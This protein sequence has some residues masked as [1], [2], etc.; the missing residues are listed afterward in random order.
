[1]PE[2]MTKYHGLMRYADDMVWNFPEG[3][4]GFEER[5]RFLPVELAG[6]RPV[7]F[8][9]SLEDPQLCFVTLPVPV[10]EYCSKG[11][12]DEALSNSVMLTARCRLVS[13]SS[14]TT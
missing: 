2:C 3:L 4:F 14:G 9:Q 8:L 10:F 13:R 12:R 7:V 11:A 1:M 5:K 6:T